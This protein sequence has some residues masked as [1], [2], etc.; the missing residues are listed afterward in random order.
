[1]ASGILLGG[2]MFHKRVKHPPFH[3]NLTELK[4]SFDKILLEKGKRYYLGHGGPLDRAQVIKYYDNH[5]KKADNT[6]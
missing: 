6:A 4:K 2:I 1:M 3:D 5:L